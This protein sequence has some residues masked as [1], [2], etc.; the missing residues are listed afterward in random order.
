MQVWIWEATDDG[1]YE[2]AGVLNG[3]TQDVKCATSLK[4]AQFAGGMYIETACVGACAGIRTRSLSRHA[5]TMIPSN[6]GVSEATRVAVVD[7][8]SYAFA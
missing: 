2:C 6:F 8:A 4:T 3:H 1:N 7:V 5:P